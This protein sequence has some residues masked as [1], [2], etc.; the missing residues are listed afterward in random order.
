MNF[1]DEETRLEFHKGN[2]YMQ[3]L[4]QAFESMCFGYS[5]QVTVI[6]VVDE[7]NVVL[8][9]GLDEDAAIE[10]LRTF[11]QTYGRLESDPSLLLVSAEDSLWLV[12]G[13]SGK[14]LANLI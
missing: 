3:L 14:N 2:T 5:V 12:H 9:A 7:N 6:D 4:A 13:D 10:L 1:V 8:G 11:N